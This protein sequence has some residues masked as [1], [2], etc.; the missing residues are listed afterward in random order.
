MME[1]SAKKGPRDRSRSRTI[2][3]CSSPIKHLNATRVGFRPQILLE[4]DTDARPLGQN[5]ASKQDSNLKSRSVPEQ[6]TAEPDGPQE[7]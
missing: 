5:A 7:T 3:A 2:S 6:Y 1:S 4:P